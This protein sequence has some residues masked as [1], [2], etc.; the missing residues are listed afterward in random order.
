MKSP[1]F[2]LGIFE[3][4]VIFSFPP[5]SFWDWEWWVT[6]IFEDFGNF[7]RVLNPEKF[8][9]IFYLNFL[10]I[11][12]E[13]QAPCSVKKSAPFLPPKIQKLA[14]LAKKRAPLSQ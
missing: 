3:E 14:K 6:W 1:F 12:A 13:L 5:F 8:P 2:C 7:S 11:I 4:C 9:A 10:Q